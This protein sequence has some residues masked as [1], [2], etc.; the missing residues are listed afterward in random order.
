MLRSLII[1]PMFLGLALLS[2]P[3]GADLADEV[4]SELERQIIQ[5]YVLSHQREASVQTEPRSSDKHHNKKKGHRHAKSKAK[6]K[7]LPPGLAKRDTLPPGLAK[8][9]TL[10]PGLQRRDF[11]ADL[12]RQLPAPR[13]G[14]RRVF[15]DGRAVL[16]EA[17][18][19]Q[20]LD[21]LEDPLA[22]P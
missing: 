3:A 2:M 12:K 20:V 14:T 11:P 17:A 4:F 6:K 5:R 7:G 1:T 15:V 21:I 19:S 16:I 18:T 22:R 9:K 13:A 8:R 10:P